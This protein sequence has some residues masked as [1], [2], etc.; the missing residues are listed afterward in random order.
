MEKAAK[1]GIGLWRVGSKGHCW[2]LRVRICRKREE[3]KGRLTHLQT[4]RL[5]G[6]KMPRIF[7]HSSGAGRT[8]NVAGDYF[9]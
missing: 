5:T 6:I 4:S 3:E 1:S 7:S 8:I 2:I 9:H